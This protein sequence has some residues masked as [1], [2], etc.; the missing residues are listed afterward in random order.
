M[1]GEAWAWLCELVAPHVLVWVGEGGFE[2][3][4]EG[5]QDADLVAGWGKV[6]EFGGME[7]SG[8]DLGLGGWEF[9]DLWG[10]EG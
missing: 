5:L 8:E 10:W 6:G 1:S 2:G 4:E 9:E 3:G 7:H